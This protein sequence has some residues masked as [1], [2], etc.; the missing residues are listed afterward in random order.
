M[1]RRGDV[2]ILFEMAG[3]VANGMLQERVNR[4]PGS[5]KT[6][7]QAVKAGDATLEVRVIAPAARIDLFACVVGCEPQ[8]IGSIKPD[9]NIRSMRIN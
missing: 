6:V 9:T 1:L 4:R 7:L 2:A 8:L 3:K 5:L